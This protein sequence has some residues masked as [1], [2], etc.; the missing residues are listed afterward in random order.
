VENFGP[1]LQILQRLKMTKINISSIKNN[2]FSLLLIPRQNKLECLS[3]T[4]FFRADLG[5]AAG[6]L[7]KMLRLITNLGS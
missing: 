2:L 3:P 6:L 4:I 1:V 5:A 7:N